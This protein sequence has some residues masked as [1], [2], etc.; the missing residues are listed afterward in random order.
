MKTNRNHR[1]P[2]RVQLELCG[3][4]GG[5]LLPITLILVALAMPSLFA[6]LGDVGVGQLI[7]LVLLAFA[8]YLFFRVPAFI[9]SR[10]TDEAFG[11]C[12]NSRPK[13]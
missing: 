11:S 13:A 12:N 9:K 3:F 2:T 4:V 1:Q 8:I 6:V 5:I 10:L 7:G